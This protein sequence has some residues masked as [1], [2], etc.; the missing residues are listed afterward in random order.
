MLAKRFKLDPAVVASQAL[1][2]LVD[3]ASLLVLFSLAA[4]MLR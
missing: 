2:T 4:L 1:T 3:A